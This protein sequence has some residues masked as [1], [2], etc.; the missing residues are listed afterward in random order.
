[1]TWVDGKHAI[2]TGGGSGIGAAVTRRLLDE[3]A[4]VTIV[5]RDAGRLVA[6]AE[7]LGARY[8]VADIT[9]RGQ[10]ST[11]FAA[12]A[13]DSGTIDILINNAGAAEAVPFAKMHDDHWDR[14]IA[15]N[16]TGVYNCAK[17]AIG[18]M[19]HQ[20][21]GRIVN[22][23][24]TAAVT[25]YAY[26]S[27]Y[28]AAKHGVLGLTRALALE[29]ATKGITVNAV[30]PGYT[31]TDIVRKAVEQIAAKTGRSKDDALAELVRTNPQGRLIQP[32]EVADAVVW[33]CHQD[34]MTGQAITVAGGEVM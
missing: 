5:G 9:D 7:E 13:R 34:S 19:L 3:G 21:S 27:A 26:V 1:M 12:A 17:A 31:D 14:M 24:S 29:Y 6:K 22:I 2:V 32:D 23:A 30:C 25:G 11:A 16:L 20:G 8:Q 28:C 15:V 10:I 4:A 33:L 18:D